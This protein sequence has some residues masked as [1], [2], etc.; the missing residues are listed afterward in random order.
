MDDAETDGGLS[1]SPLAFLAPQPSSHSYDLTTIVL[2]TRSLGNSLLQ[3]YWD[4]ILPIFPLLHR[5][6]FEA[7]YSRVW[8]NVGASFS[9]HVTGRIEDVL[10]HSILNMVF[11]LGSQA[12]ESFTQAQ[13]EKLADE[14]YRRSQALISVET[15]DF[16]SLE[17]VQLLLLRGLYLLYTPH[18]DRCWNMVG[19][20]IRV[21]QG[22]DLHDACLDETGKG[23]LTREMRRRVWCN[24]VALD[25]LSA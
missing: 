12:N 16:S 8:S 11:S 25:R 13:K 20:A 4:F 3:C 21:A 24:C 15:L 6:T 23:Q 7:A 19:L 17:V 10:F 1:P 18:T 5:P 22:L 9:A 14:F 2:P